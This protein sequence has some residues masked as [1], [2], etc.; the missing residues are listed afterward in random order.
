M[1]NSW[2]LGGHLN[3]TQQKLAIGLWVAAFDQCAPAQ[4][5]LSGQGQKLPSFI[6]TILCDVCLYFVV[7][8]FVNT[9]VY[10]PSF[11]PFGNFVRVS[12]RASVYCSLKAMNTQGHN[13]F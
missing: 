12:L 9:C 4:A 3:E 8:T 7:K 6:H 11:N 2:T 10:R 13:C 5:W 1:N